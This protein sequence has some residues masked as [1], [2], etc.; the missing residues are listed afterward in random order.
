MKENGITLIKFFI[1]ILIILVLITI[2]VSTISDSYK[3]YNLKRYVSEMTL[4]QEK[5]N[6]IRND[7]KVWENYNPNETGN[8]YSYLQSLNFINASSASNIYIDKFNKIIDDL[9]KNDLKYWNKNADSIIT[10][11]YYFDPARIEKNFGINDSNLYI[12][13]NFYTGNVISRDGIE[14]VKNKKII[15]RR[16]ESEIG[17]KLVIN[18]IYN[19]DIKTEIKI[20]EN[21][22][23]K[24]T[25]KISLLS[26]DIK[27]LPNISEIYYFSNK[28]E[29]IRKKCSNTNIR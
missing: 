15:Y 4:I 9:N 27:T 3:I 13:I 20:I 11:Y 29:E 18:N 1:I 26:D 23:L 21:R 12:I 22:G 10:N 7:Y 17:N 19:D 8:F 2:C 16:Y 28:N 5:I 24:Q 14:D 6:Q 25:V